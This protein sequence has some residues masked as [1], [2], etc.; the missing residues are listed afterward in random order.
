MKDERFIE[1]LDLD[2]EHWVDDF[3]SGVETRRNIISLLEAII[4]YAH[5]ST[6]SILAS[7]IRLASRYRDPKCADTLFRMSCLNLALEVC[8]NRDTKDAGILCVQEAIVRYRDI[9]AC[10]PEPSSCSLWIALAGVTVKRHANVEVLRLVLH[11]Y[12]KPRDSGT[13]DA[14]VRFFG[15]KDYVHHS[16]YDHAI[17]QVIAQTLSI[18]V[19]CGLTVTASRVVLAD[20]VRYAR[21][22]AQLLQQDDTLSEALRRACYEGFNTIIR[23]ALKLANSEVAGDSSATPEALQAW[24]LCVPLSAES[25]VPLRIAWAELLATVTAHDGTQGVLLDEID[26]LA[27]D[28]EEDVRLAVVE[29]LGVMASQAQCCSQRAIAKLFGFGLKDP[30]TSV[31]LRAIR[32]LI[33]VVTEGKCLPINRDRYAQQGMELQP[34][35]DQICGGLRDGSSEVRECWITLVVAY[36]KQVANV[37]ALLSSIPPL[38]S[39]LTQTALRDEDGAV[40]SRAMNHL[41]DIHQRFPQLRQYTKRLLSDAIE[42]SIH[43]PDPSIRLRGVYAIGALMVSAQPTCLVEH[44]DETSE[45]GPV[46]DIH[47]DTLAPAIPHLLKMNHALFEGDARV[48]HAVLEVTLD[49]LVRFPAESSIIR[50]VLMS[51]PPVVASDALPVKSL[52]ERLVDAVVPSRS[53]TALVASELAS[54]FSNGSQRSSSR[55]LAIKLFSSLISQG[56]DGQDPPADFDYAIPMA[57]SLA[58]Y[59]RHGEGELQL[60]AIELLITLSMTATYPSRYFIPLVEKLMALLEDETLRVSVVKLLSLWSSYVTVRKKINVAIVTAG[61][62]TQT[63]SMTLGQAELLLRMVLDRRFNFQEPT[64][65]TTI[66]HLS[67]VLDKPQLAF[68]QMKLC[69]ALWS[70]YGSGFIVDGI[71]QGRPPRYVLRNLGWDNFDGPYVNRLPNSETI[72]IDWFRHALFGRHT[73]VNEVTDWLQYCRQWLTA[74]QENGQKP[75]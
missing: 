56:R 46:S 40:R 63:I 50:V 67:S 73:T 70:R 64:D 20:I 17:E 22:L 5:I 75:T 54:I 8:R 1:V 68:Y 16:E 61:L 36:I 25:D 38:V 30:H 31:R 13:F 42:A 71:F 26:S 24:L 6:P 2:P 47:A 49:N 44:S 10:D 59:D 28:E 34:T 29:L 60:A 4:D 66:L 27:Q 69:T 9:I 7:L 37:D 32:S 53:T 52:A 74:S 12:E 14:A 3:P 58:L 35:Q 23:A 55:R 62:A 33:I 21:L 18:N 39:P 15:P 43:D 57:T 19:E 65:Y 51:I 45:P 48:R 41:K 72:L 11:F